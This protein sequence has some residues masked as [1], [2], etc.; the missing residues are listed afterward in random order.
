MS[1]EEVKS[2]ISR[3]RRSLRSARNVLEAG[4]HDFAMSRVYYAMFYATT[5]ALI[6]QGIKRSKHSGALAAFGQHLVKPGKS[7]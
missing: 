2:L 5:A 1:P 6:S 3:A 7:A 4:D